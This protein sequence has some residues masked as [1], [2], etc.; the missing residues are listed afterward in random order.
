MSTESGK[1]MCILCFGSVIKRVSGKT[2]SGIRLKQVNTWKFLSMKVGYLKTED[3]RNL[4]TPI[5]AACSL[6]SRS[7][8]APKTRQLLSPDVGP[9]RA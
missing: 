5:D 2:P 4:R 8:T 1:C 6:Q 7:R 9:D 3:Y